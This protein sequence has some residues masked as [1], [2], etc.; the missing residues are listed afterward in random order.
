MKRNCWIICLLILSYWIKLSWKCYTLFKKLKYLF[1]Y[2]KAE[3]AYQL[4][5][6]QT[7]F[8]TIC[9]SSSVKAHPFNPHRNTIL[10]SFAKCISFCTAIRLQSRRCVQTGICNNGVL[11][12]AD[13]VEWTRTERDKHVLY[14]L[15]KDLPLRMKKKHFLLP[16]SMTLSFTF[17]SFNSKRSFGSFFIF[18]M[19]LNC[20]LIYYSWIN[21]QLFAQNIMLFSS[22]AFLTKLSRFKP[23]SL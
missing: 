19:T 2:Q 3:L 17:F 12:F 18:W 14:V 1:I 8:C 15:L 22:F 9:S 5:N 21:E 4:Y 16:F 13:S 6:S 20:C 11:F 7:F 23:D 10:S